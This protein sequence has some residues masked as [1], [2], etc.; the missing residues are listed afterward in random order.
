M[1]AAGSLILSPFHTLVY[2]HVL[3]SV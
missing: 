3:Q 2:R 1:K